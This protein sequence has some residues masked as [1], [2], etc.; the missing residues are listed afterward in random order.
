MAAGARRSA[1]DVP[2]H[3]RRGGYHLFYRDA[4]RHQNAQSL[5]EG[6]DIRGE[7]GYVVA[8]PSIHPN[9]RTY[10]WEQEPGEYEIAQVNNLAVEFLLG[11]VP[12]KKHQYFQMPD[13]IPEGKRV[14]SLMSLVGSL[15]DKG[16]LDES[17]RDSV[18]RENAMR[19]IPPLTDQELEQQVFPALKR[20]WM[21][22]RPYTA[23]TDK[24]KMK[25][26]EKKN[27]SYSDADELI[28]ADLPPTVFLVD[29]ILTQGLGGLSAKSKLGKSWLALQLSVDLALGDKFLG[30][31]TKKCGVLYIDLENTKSLTQERLRAVLDGREP[32]E[33]GNL[34][35]AHDF[36]LMG[37]GF[38]E[39]LTDFLINIKT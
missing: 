23:T 13:T 15:K 19:C 8:P 3:Y 6:I 9:G 27:I 35:F 10:E 33:H 38:E 36:N 20:G 2:E 28:A 34:I 21:S 4:A 16:M 1:G 30:F 12:E 29:G 14:S 25:A 31:S 24:G 39:D 22:E 37:E 32:P 11:P 17:I 18:H 7:G 5:Y 26:L